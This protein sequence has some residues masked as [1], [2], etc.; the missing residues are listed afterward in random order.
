MDTHVDP[1]A[2]EVCPVEAAGR[3]PPEGEAGQPGAAR[4][5]VAEGPPA[6][7]AREPAAPT[8]AERAA[9]E[10]LHEPYRARCRECVSSRGLS[11]G[12]QTKDRQESALAAVG[13]DYGYLGE[14]EDATPLL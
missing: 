4:E 9:H 12:R 11:T 2:P 14:R 7:P 1:H 8:A 13:V 10:V 5:E 3:E 6:R